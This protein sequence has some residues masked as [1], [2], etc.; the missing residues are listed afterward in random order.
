MSPPREVPI[1]MTSLVSSA[2]AGSDM[3]ISQARSNCVCIVLKTLGLLG[4]MSAP[5]QFVSVLD[6]IHVCV[7]VALEVPNLIVDPD[8]AVVAA[9]EVENDRV[10]VVVRQRALVGQNRENPCKRVL[11]A[12]LSGSQLD[13]VMGGT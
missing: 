6:A 1:K 3:M 10:V 13:G 8:A 4:V 2:N 7:G 12:E 9:G 5:F 11:L